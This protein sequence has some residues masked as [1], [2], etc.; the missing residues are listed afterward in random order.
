VS[1][2]RDP[3]VAGSAPQDS[4][5]A[6]APATSAPRGPRRSQAIVLAAIVVALTAVFGLLGVRL[7]FIQVI[8]HESH[9][10]I[11]RR[12][13]RRTDSIPAYPGD[14]RTSDGVIAARSMSAFD[15]GLDP[16]RLDDVAVRRAVEVLAAELD[17]A[18]E[19]RRAVLARALRG[20]QSG[21][22]Y[23]RVARAV[24]P[25][26]ADAARDALR[27]ALTP[28]TADESLV[29]DR[30]TRRVYPLGEILGQV[31]GVSDLDGEGQEGAERTQ[32]DSLRPHEGRRRVVTDAREELRFFLPE[33]VEVAPINGEDVV[34]TIDS[35]A[36]VILAEELARGI[37]KHRAE[38]GQ[39]VLMDCRTGAVLA[40]ASWPRYDP[41]HYHVYPREELLRR[42]KNR[43]IENLFE[44]GSVI[45]PFIVATA[46][47]R[48]LARRDEPMWAGG[49]FHSIGGRR[50]E[51][52][53]DHGPMNVEDSLVYSSNI[54]L[55]LIGMR[56]GRDGLIDAL[57][58]FGLGRKTGIG[59][60]FEAK[61]GHTRREEWNEVYS[62]V[63]VSIGY[64]VMVSPL[65]LCAALAAAINGG[66]LYKPQI[67]ERY[68]RGD[69][70][71]RVEPQLVGRPIQEATSQTIR[72][73]LRRVVQ[74]GTGQYLRMEGFEFG[75]KTGTADLDPRYTKKDYLS[76]FE[77]FAP[78]DD[79]QVVA[80]V[81][82]EKSR[83]GKYYGGTVAGPV[84]ARTF[85]RYF[86]VA[87]EPRFEKM[88]IPGW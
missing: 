57:D 53:S 77:A 12:G 37:E 67:V 8:A 24:A 18:A 25:E 36:Q 73:A 85:R 86:R 32:R 38:A 70:E 9:L 62:T 40:M 54:G 35:R 16:L 49:R 34:L 26:L 14:V 29:V 80:L 19:E 79:P 21:G 5:P 63:S 45:K 10:Q 4:L 59:L 66:Y 65:Q 17:L 44:P 6:P 1:A 13:V 87:A 3:Q 83:S 15:I 55:S 48:G 22:R 47:E 50:I 20:R 88:K 76:S 56:L 64:E 58:R 33:N 61:G 11:A 43:V 31:V 69:A 81:M 74:E 68:V 42:R 28:A 60:P 51:D 75:G 71:R 52:V 72:D 41:N 78:Y 84:V 46:L 82:I 2:A 27:Q 30:V 39:A 23:A 7:F